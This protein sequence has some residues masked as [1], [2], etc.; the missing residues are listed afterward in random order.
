ME[1]IAL[2]GQYDPQV[3]ALIASLVPEGF[4]LKEIASRDEYKDLQEANY[5]IL[6]IL[7]LNEDDINNLPN[8][9]LIQRWGVGYDKVDVKAA[10][11][12]NIP[13]TIT[14]GMNS[15][16]VSEMAVLLMLAV[17]R[18][19]V[20]LHNNV[21]SGKW[22]EGVGASS[23]YTIDEKIVGLIG[24]G[25]IGKKVAQKVQAFG[26]KVQYYDAFRLPLEEEE[27]L[28]V[29]YAQLKNC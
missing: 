26:A 2:T 12:R 15:A 29:T 17:Y 18:N 9:K 10:G 8:L 24:F 28:G 20:G 27:K 5:V 13:V 1:V 4:I 7:N 19:L 21:I 14:P 11:R 6:R 25:N 3:K 16:A 23:A 22:Q